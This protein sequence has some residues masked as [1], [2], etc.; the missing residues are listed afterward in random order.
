MFGNYLEFSCT[1]KKL[2][3]SLTALARDHGGRRRRRDLHPPAT[4]NTS[5]TRSVTLSVPSL[6]P[7]RIPAL[8]SL[9]LR[10]SCSFYSYP[11][12]SFVAAT[13]S[14]QDVIAGCSVKGK[15]GEV[16]AAAV[17]EVIMVLSHPRLRRV[18][19]RRHRPELRPPTSTGHR[20]G[21][22]SSGDFHPVGPCI[23]PPTS[24][25]SHR[26]CRGDELRRCCPQPAPAWRVRGRRG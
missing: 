16:G 19:A 5:A 22:L 4:S 2:S 17:K 15:D 6:H 18:G 20:S 11:P 25:P 12:L 14:S 9:G 23:A 24:I 10:R 7:P 3:R 26:R 1:C 13:G 8:P 21:K